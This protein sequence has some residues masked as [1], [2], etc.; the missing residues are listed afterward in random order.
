[1]KKISPFNLDRYGSRAERMDDLN[2]PEGL[3]SLSVC[4]C[5]VM[6]FMLVDFVCLKVV[7]NL[8][9]TEN[10]FY[11]IC[12]AAACA[13]VLDL[14]MSVAAKVLKKYNQG[15]CDRKEKNQII[16]LAIAAFMIAF[17]FSF[18][19]RIFTKDVSFSS[20]TGE[21]LTNTLSM[22]AQT[23]TSDPSILVAALFNGVIPLLTSL[24]SFIVSYY[25]YDPLR[26]KLG[27][28]EKG[29]IGLQ[30]NIHEAEK[31]LA[32]TSGTEQYCNELIA[33]EGD[34]YQEFM[35]QIGA[36]A[37]ELK[38][39]VRVLIMKKLGTPE[40]VSV[41]SEAGIELLQSYETDN[42]PGQELPG[43]IDGQI[44][45]VDE[46]KEVITPFT[47]HAA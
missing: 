34:L 17:V 3:L 30:A 16:I 18:C 6:F 22:T 39:M 7:W 14:P 32:E 47:N 23:D 19:F 41:M 37:L 43:F 8:V 29:R 12:V 9:M 10:P 20:G 45:G 5:V 4:D 25:M 44:H 26:S 42:R 27:R 2:R 35:S 24:A 1:M 15:L 11:V 28:L 21:T 46:K 36:D 38:Q 33:R 13:V 40:Y 31:A